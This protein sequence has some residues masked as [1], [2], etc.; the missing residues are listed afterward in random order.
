MEDASIA[1]PVDAQAV[2]AKL[3]G[4]GNDLYGEIK[5]VLEHR[6]SSISSEQNRIRSEIES[7]NQKLLGGETSLGRIMDADMAKAAT[8]LATSSI[9]SEMAVQVMGNSSKMKDILIP[10][11]TNHFRGAPMQA[12][13]F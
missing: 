5:C 7:M 8:E 6:I 10:L 2:M 4:N 12:R 11:T 9:K 1:T 3:S 13:L